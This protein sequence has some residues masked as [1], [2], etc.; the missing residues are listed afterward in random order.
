MPKRASLGVTVTVGN[1]YPVNSQEAN[2]ISTSENTRSA[3]IVGY[4]FFCTFIN[5]RAYLMQTNTI[6][7]IQTSRILRIPDSVKTA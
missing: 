5:E 1:P 3:K 6:Q 7:Y 2:V 4:D